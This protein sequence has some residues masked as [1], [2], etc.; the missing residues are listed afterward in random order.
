M[1]LYLQVIFS[2][3]GSLF[4]IVNSEEKALLEKFRSVL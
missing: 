3:V 4:T 2:Y 1:Q